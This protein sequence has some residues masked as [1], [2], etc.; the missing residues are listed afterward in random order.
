[1][2]D[3]KFKLEVLKDNLQKISDKEKECLKNLSFPFIPDFNSDF[4]FSK[5]KVLLV[6]Q[7]TKGWQGRLEEFLKDDL[8]IDIVIANSK[9]RYQEL[10]EGSAKRSS[11]HQFMKKIKKINHEEPIQWLNFYS[12]D[13]KKSSFNKLS[14]QCEYQKIYTELENFSIQNLSEQIIRLKPK[15]IFFVGQYHNNF[16]KLE[17][18][19]EVFKS[20]KVTLKEPINKFNMKI[21]ND[22]ILVFRVPHPA[23]FS[24][25]SQEAR[26]AALQYL[27]IF[28]ECKNISDFKSK[29]SFI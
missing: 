5:N 14:K 22:E 27:K 19:L 4:D 6:G 28:D 7:E 2:L 29:I 25:V 18:R 20:E 12:F 16:P 9:K 26:K 3:Y 1:M 23:H 13:Y 21:W 15:V 8:N 10:Y 17:E 24:S 11:F